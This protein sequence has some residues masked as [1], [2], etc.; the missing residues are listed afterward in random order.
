MNKFKLGF[1]VLLMALSSMA[2]ADDMYMTDI[3][4][5]ELEA[6]N[7]QTKSVVFADKSYRYELDVEK[8]SYRFPADAK[9]A[10]SFSNLKVGE[11]YYFELLAKGDDDVKTQNYKYVTFISQSKPS[12]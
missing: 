12:E 4:K 9:T 7:S 3:V 11:Q 1:N 2:V 5:H 6:V 8:S 10:L